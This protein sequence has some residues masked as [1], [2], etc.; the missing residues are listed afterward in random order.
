MVS[1]G[2]IILSALMVAA[3]MILNRKLPEITKKLHEFGAAGKWGA[4]IGSLIGLILFLNIMNPLQVGSVILALILFLVVCPFAGAY[5]GELIVRKDPQAALAPA[6][7]AYVTYLCTTI[8]KLAAVALTVY[9]V[10]NT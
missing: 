8:V 9:F 3:S 4:T 10:I 6:G 7:A 5:I 2:A 1:W